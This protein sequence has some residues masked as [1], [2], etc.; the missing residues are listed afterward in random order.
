MLSKR[1]PLLAVIRASSPEEAINRARGVYAG[2]FRLIEITATVPR[3]PDVVRELVGLTG[4]LIG[5]GTITNLAQADDFLAAGAQFLVSPINL[6]RLVEVSRSAGVSC[7]VGGMTPTEIHAAWQ[8]GADLIKVFPV[9]AMGGLVYLK[10]LAEPFGELPILAS[11]GI[12]EHNY[13]AYLHGGAKLVSFG[14]FLW[15][16]DPQAQAEKLCAPFLQD[17]DT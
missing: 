3:A 14:S 13:R 10:D 11:G 6:L 15:Q 9:R 12:D 5:G 16:G 8:A 4:A 17:L 2:G 7:A 1:P